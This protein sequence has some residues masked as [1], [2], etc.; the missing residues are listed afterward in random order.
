MEG[1]VKK[2][3]LFAGALLSVALFAGAASAANLVTNGSFET[4][5]GNGQLGYNTTATGWSVSSTPSDPSTSYVFLWNPTPTATTSGTTADNGGATGYL[6]SVSLWG[7]G[8]TGGGVSNGLTV[9]P[10]GGAFIGEDPVYDNTSPA[11]T[12][13]ITGLTAGDNYYVTFYWAAG[14]QYGYNGD[15]T[16]GWTVDLGSGP[17]QSTVPFDLNN[18]AFSGWMEQTFTFTADNSSDVL[19]FVADGGPS[20]ALPPF[21]LLDGVSVTSVPEPASWA[22]MLLGVGALGA[23]LRMRRREVLATA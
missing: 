13:T 5:G 23:G 4:N 16:E 1:I 10:D 14:Q 20:Y 7:P 17:S 9:S 21:A 18:E 19:S 12:Q 6:G 2:S 22:L 8:S 3:S 11:I 15:T